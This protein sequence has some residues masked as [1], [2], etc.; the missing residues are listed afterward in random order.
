M[1]HFIL[2]TLLFI[3]PP[4]IIISLLEG[5]I[6]FFYEDFFSET[7]LEQLFYKEISDYKWI[8]NIDSDNLIVL[9]GSS[10]VRYALSCS[11][12]N[13][14]NPD[15]YSY[16]NIAMDARDP[17]A[18]YFIIKS[19][20]LN[21][22]SSIYMGLDPWIFAKRY[23][24]YRKGYLYLD[25]KL[26]ELFKYSKEHDRNAFFKRY[27]NLLSL[28]KNSTPAYYDS[29]TNIP[30]DFGSVSL[31]RSDVNFNDLRDWFQIESFGWSDLQFEYL[32]KIQDY[33]AT[34][35]IKFSLFIPP[36]RS[37]YSNSYKR[38]FKDTHIDYVNKLDEN[39]IT[40][41]IFGKFNQL[42]TIGDSLFF[43]EAYHLNEKGQ[44]R[45]SEI[46]YNMTL[47][48]NECFS[49]NYNWFDGD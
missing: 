23:Y 17:I 4:L 20:D 12:L 28:F 5:G 34:N 38:N 14:L 29:V 45:Y 1:K 39:G 27:K 18:T 15:G 26:S 33:C 13:E 25:F 2:K 41:L 35:N 32:R 3:S 16:V 40:A 46:F 43:A 22:I 47:L 49:K 44:K 7:K 9:A 6:R 19:L 21:K 31:N 36:K 8:N 42:D 11:R 24:K 10:S 37:D 30:S 48:E